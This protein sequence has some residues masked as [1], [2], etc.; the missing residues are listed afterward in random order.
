[1]TNFISNALK[2]TP[3]G[4]TVTVRTRLIERRVRCEVQDTGPGVPADERNQLF[5]EHGRLSPKPTAGEE[6][7]GVGLAIVK[8]LVE[9]QRGT[10]G[11]DFPAGGGSIFWFE[12]PGA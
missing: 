5:L 12:L 3:R 7:H 9:S 10:V 6:S 8:H 11:A 2:F 1:M 4:G